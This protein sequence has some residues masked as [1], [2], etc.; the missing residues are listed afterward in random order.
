MMIENER[1]G[2]EA[3]KEAEEWRGAEAW[4]WEAMRNR[5]DSIY[6]EWVI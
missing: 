2:K 3:E 1:E 5:Y 6:E 4:T